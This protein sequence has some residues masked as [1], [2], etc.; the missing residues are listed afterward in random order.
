M[1]NKTLVDHLAEN[2][3][4]D[5]NNK[6]RMILGELGTNKKWDDPDAYIGA[7]T[8][9]QQNGYDPDHAVIAG[10]L[11]AEMAETYGVLNAERMRAL[12]YDPEKEDE[13]D[14]GRLDVWKEL[15]GDE[16]DAE[17]IQEHKEEWIDGKI[18]SWGDMKQYS[19]RMMEFLFDGLDPDAIDYCMGEEDTDYNQ[20]ELEKRE[21]TRLK[22]KV[23]EY[24]EETEKEYETVKDELAHVLD[25]FE[26]DTE[27]LD[28]L[29][30]LYTRCMSSYHNSRGSDFDLGQ[31]IQDLDAADD[32]VLE[33]FDDRFVERLMDVS[34]NRERFENLYESKRRDLE[35]TK[36]MK[37][38]LLIQK[39][40]L[41]DQL[42]QLD[43][44]E[45]Q[46]SFTKFTKQYNIEPEDAE[47]L[48]LL[49]K[50]ELTDNIKDMFPDDLQDRLS[51]HISRYA[52]LEGYDVDVDADDINVEMFDDTMVIHNTKDRSNTTTLFGIDEAEMEVIYRNAI[53]DTLKDED[54]V[55]D[56]VIVPHGAGGFVTKRT[57]VTP[58]DR[59]RDGGYRDDPNMVSLMTLPVYQ[60]NDDLLTFKEKGFNTWDIKRIDK[61][62][63]SSG[64]VIQNQL[65][66][67]SEIHEFIHHTSLAK[68]GEM[69]RELWKLEEGTEEYEQLEEQIAQMCDI[70]PHSVVPF[71]DVHYGAANQEGTPSN[72][73]RAQRFTNFLDQVYDGYGDELLISETAEGYL[74]HTNME[75]HVFGDLP[76]VMR[77]QIVDEAED[78]FENDYDSGEELAVDLFKYTMDMANAMTTNMERT[79]YA[80]RNKQLDAVEN[81]LEQVI[82]AIEPVVY[83]LVSGNHNRDSAGGD[84]AHDLKRVIKM[85]DRDAEEGD[86]MFIFDSGG[87]M[88]GGYGTIV[89]DSGNRVT[90]RHKMKGGKHEHRN[91]AQQILEANWGSDE[92]LVNHGHT[93]FGWFTSGTAGTETAAQ[94]GPDAYSSTRGFGNPVYG[95]VIKYSNEAPEDHPAND[96]IYHAWHHVYDDTLENGEFDGDALDEVH[97]QLADDLSDS[98]HDILDMS[99]DEL[100]DDLMDH[101][102]R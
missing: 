35:E 6:E 91:K 48:Y 16:E 88:H 12:G 56:T 79:P 24:K 70:H 41:E 3:A 28:N 62:L 58:E 5:E 65:D 51:T 27:R 36:E 99:E 14:N 29:K 76:N 69:Q 59:R 40:D 97:E 81:S 61:H 80:N 44:E 37:D 75:K 7:N 20:K 15:I 93:P 60:S 32:P 52:D 101:V 34:D 100:H 17:Y 78:V 31:Y 83:S 19:K 22:R 4:Y 39:E 26:E 67:D 102:H 77:D 92:V 1:G 72:Y 42:A 98:F 54:R 94:K 84:E 46:G 55:P 95:G 53:Q 2:T 73:Q 89:R 74:D 23:N 85:H 96:M 18:S 82:D 57:N 68:L 13:E 64:M 25:Q 9:L 38:D 10:G 87:D 86:N 43:R 90:Y 11:T 33:P 49:T 71:T 8:F 30:N 50:N 66:D 45:E 47:E 63:H 21:L